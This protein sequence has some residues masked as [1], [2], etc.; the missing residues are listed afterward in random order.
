MGSIAHIVR[1]CLSKKIYEPHNV[2]WGLFPP[3]E[4]ACNKAQRGEKRYER[5][6]N[7]FAAWKKL[8]EE[9]INLSTLN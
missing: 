8:L 4:E 1:T 2:H 3:L 7:D 9:Q 6:V 5:G